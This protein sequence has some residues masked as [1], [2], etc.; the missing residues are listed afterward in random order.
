VYLY[1]YIDMRLERMV[2]PKARRRWW[3]PCAA[4]ASTAGLAAVPALAQ[5]ADFSQAE[6]QFEQLCESC[7]GEGGGGGDRGPALI[8]NRDLRSRNTGQIRDLIKNGTPGGM[9]AFPLPDRELQALAAWLHSLNLSAYSERPAG[10][11]AAGEQFFFG[12]GQCST[13]HMVHGRGKSNGPDLSDIGLRSTVPEIALV[14]ENP[15]SQMGMHTTASCPSWAFCPDEAWAVVQVRLKDGSMLR[16]FARNQAEHD[17]QLQT[18]DG[19]MHLLT[20]DDYQEIT[21]EKQSYMPPL[22]ATANERRDLIAYL[23]SLARSSPGPLTT[24]TERIASDAIQ[25]ITTPKHGEWPTYNGVPGGN[26]YSPLDQINTKNVSHLQLEWVHS[27]PGSGLETTPLVSDGVMYVTAPGHV[28]ALDSRTGREIWCYAQSSGAFSGGRGSSPSDPNRGV[29]LLGDRVFFVTG[30]AH[31]ICLHRLTGGVMWDVKMPV[32]PGPFSATSAPLVVGDLVISGI[33][34][35]DGPL[36]GFL[37][38]YKATTGQLAWRFWTVPNPGEPGSET[39]KGNA[40]A[41]GGGATWLTGSYDVQTDTLY[42]AVGNPFPATDGDEREGTNLYTNCV[43]ALDAKTGKLRWYYQFTPHDLHDWDAT[44]PFVLVDTTYQGRDRKLLLQANR[45]GFVYVL[46]RTNGELLLGKPFV[47]KLNW[48][49]G[50]WPDGKP[51]ILPANKPTK[52]G[53]KTCP[54]VRGA[55]NWYSTSFHPETKFFYVMAV[56][57]CSIYSQSQRGGY[58]GFRDPSDSG[59]KY[60]RAIDITTGKIVW[61]VPQI[62][63]QEANYSGVLTTAGGLLFYGE[64]G[65]RFAAVDVKTGK[66][67][68]TFKATEPWKAS[69]MTYMV[70]GRQHIAIASGGNI[71]SFALGDR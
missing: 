43:L 14:L 15:T 23:S 70:N 17:L 33:A 44:E 8:S 53:V 52:T 24:E 51:Q 2:R 60:L 30:D 10:N 16:G 38:A 13:C 65:G 63:P 21:R 50:I 59:L 3:L 25:A 4:L 18:F 47:R 68:V 41:T 49:S 7:H 32:T 1:I 58:E 46:D 56:E 26:R 54:S 66:T 45:N 62:G 34:G 37:A 9:P 20:E 27:L 29:A 57:D 31:L 22:K 67:L 55:T 19:R 28:C 40:I 11:T 71:L 48:A 5:V 6:K 12:S 61:E 64:T 39:W 69:P 42:W 36:R 35:G